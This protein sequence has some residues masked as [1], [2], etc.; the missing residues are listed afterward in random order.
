MPD[1]PEVLEVGKSRTVREGGDVALLAFGRMV[2]QARA[3]AE[4]LSAEGIE[5]RV[6]DMRWVKPLDAEAIEMCIR[7]RASGVPSASATMSFTAL[8]HPIWS[9]PPKNGNEPSPP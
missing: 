9:R 5:C 8:R 6:V 3:A 2:G 4:L 7:D 1:A